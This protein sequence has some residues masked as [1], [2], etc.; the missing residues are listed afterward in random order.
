MVRKESDIEDEHGLIAI[1]FDPV[2]E[3]KFRSSLRSLVKEN[4]ANTS[5]KV[6]SLARRIIYL[7]K[8]LYY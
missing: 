4:G 5:Q 1:N 8:E 2:V 7:L 3:H 6:A